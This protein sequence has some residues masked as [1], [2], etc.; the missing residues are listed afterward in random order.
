MLWQDVYAEKQM[1]DYIEGE[2]ELFQGVWFN[3]VC[4]IIAHSTEFVKDVGA[5]LRQNTEPNERIDFVEEIPSGSALILADRLNN[6]AYANSAKNGLRVINGLQRFLVDALDL[7]WQERG[8]CQGLPPL[9]RVRVDLDKGLVLPFVLADLHIVLV[10]ARRFAKGN[11]FTAKTSD[12][13]VFN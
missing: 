13:L 2:A 4:R 1:I 7:V 10:G 6:G 5:I 3:L 11:R 9:A 12:D 8:V